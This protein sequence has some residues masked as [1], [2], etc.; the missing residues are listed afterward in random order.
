MEVAAPSECSIRYSPYW[1]AGWWRL[2]KIDRAK[3]AEVAQINGIPGDR[4]RVLKNLRSCAALAP[5]WVQTCWFKLDGNAPSAESRDA[6]CDL[7][8]EV[9][10]KLAGCTST[11]WQ[12]LRNN[13]RPP[14]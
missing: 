3:D 5:T 6:Y 12:G 10:D 2:S 1:I 7:L 8:R 14:D 13:P 4:A 11:V 9:A